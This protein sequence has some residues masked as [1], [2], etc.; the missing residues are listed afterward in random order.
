MGLQEDK[1]KKSN[2][3]VQKYCQSTSGGQGKQRDQKSGWGNL[4]G[5]RTRSKFTG[6]VI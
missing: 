6:S 5:G 4:K 2:L 3:A 1:K